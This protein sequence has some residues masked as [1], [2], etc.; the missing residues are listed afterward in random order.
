[1]VSRESKDR[2]EAHRFPVLPLP[3][4]SSADE[5]YGSLFR[6]SKVRSIDSVNLRL[7]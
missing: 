3:F 4:L 2:T 5:A 7:R 6:L 1:M